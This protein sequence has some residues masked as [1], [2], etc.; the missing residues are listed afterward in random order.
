MTKKCNCASYNWRK[1]RDPQVTVDLPTWVATEKQNRT[2]CI[3]R[4]IE[5]VIQYLWS[6]HINTLSSCCGHNKANPSIVVGT[7]TDIKKVFK[8]LAEVDGRDWIV[9]RWERID[10]KASEVL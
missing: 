7:S 1:G 9:S 6:K 2:V 10:Y 4:C 3:D 5:P 8:V